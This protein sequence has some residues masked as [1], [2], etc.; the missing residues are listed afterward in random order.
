MIDVGHPGVAG[1]VLTQVS[2][3]I[4]QNIGET[5]E[6]ESFGCTG[7]TVLG[8]EAEALEHILADAGDETDIIGIEGDFESIIGVI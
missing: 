2:G 1:E 8:L 5:L 7:L 4:E 6:R 3:S